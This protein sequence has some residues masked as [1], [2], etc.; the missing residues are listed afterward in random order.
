MN[1]M[2]VKVKQGRGYISR[3]RENQGCTEPF[4]W[5]IIIIILV[6]FDIF[7]DVFDKISQNDTFWVDSGE[8]SFFLGKL[9]LRQQKESLYIIFLC[10]C[11]VKLTYNIHSC[12]FTYR[13]S[14]RTIHVKLTGTWRP[15]IHSCKFVRIAQHI[16]LGRNFQRFDLVNLCALC[17]C[18]NDILHDCRCMHFEHK[19]ATALA[20]SWGNG[21]LKIESKHVLE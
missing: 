19:Q 7:C 2:K 9:K 17:G 1:I 11:N 21:R 14:Y 16:I 8:C 13:I 18:L 20:V 4:N 5:S 15:N 10:Y 12:Y 6:S 3:V